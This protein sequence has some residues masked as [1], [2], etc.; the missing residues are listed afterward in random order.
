[1]ILKTYQIPRPRDIIVSLDIINRKMGEIEC[2]HVKDFFK[3][4]WS[5]G[6]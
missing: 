5:E 3:M 1:M 2:I 4:L 6:I